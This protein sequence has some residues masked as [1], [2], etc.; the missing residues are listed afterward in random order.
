MPQAAQTA[1]KVEALL[2]T[3]RE[4]RQ[5]RLDNLE[6]PEDQVIVTNELLGKGGFGAVY[7]AD[8]NG[9]NAAAKVVVIEHELVGYPGTRDHDA[10]SGGEN[11]AIFYTRRLVSFDLHVSELWY[12]GSR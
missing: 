3:R 10:V 9:R 11:L 12:S 2:K 7:L 6:I 1:G 4:R 5:R 8:F